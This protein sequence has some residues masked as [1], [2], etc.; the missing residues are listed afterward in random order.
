MTTRGKT[1]R[2][3]KPPCPPEHSF[4]VIVCTH[5]WGKGAWSLLDIWK[6]KCLLNS[7]GLSKEKMLTK[8]CLHDTSYRLFITGFGFL[9]KPVVNEQESK[10]DDSFK[11]VRPLPYESYIQV[12]ARS[13]SQGWFIF[14]NFDVFFLL[15]LFDFT[16]PQ[17]QGLLRW[18]RYGYISRYSSIFQDLIIQNPQARLFSAS[19][20]NLSS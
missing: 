1:L 12:L 10:A 2:K 13:N 17:P 9:V 3:R 19:L 11:R 16:W 6:Q 7:V 8:T 20:R 14:T 18:T 4:P 5:S 15:S